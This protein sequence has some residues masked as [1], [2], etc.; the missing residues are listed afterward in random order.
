MRQLTWL[1]ILTLAT[2]TSTKADTV[3]VSGRVADAAGKPITGAEVAT[4]WTADDGAMK[5]IRGVKTDGD[6]KFRLECRLY[7]RDQAVMAIDG[8]R[9]HGGLAVVAAKDTER[10]LDIV[11]RP[12]VD[13]CGHFT[14]EET[15]LAPGWTNV[16]LSL[17]PGR[18][19][20]VQCSS[21][22]SKFALK[23]PPGKYEFYGYGSFTDFEGVTREVTLEQGKALEMGALDLEL[24][25]IARH[26]GKEPPKWHVAD[27]RGLP[28][29]KDVTWKDFRGKWVILE[30]WGFW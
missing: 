30:F 10:P 13:V 9:E 6:G 5:P 25:P 26:Y 4:F 20:V 1:S 15:K 12:L 16:Y 14:C 28:Q 11:V 7:G 2:I 23:M 29:G 17:L 27:A 21:K 18:V 24:T 22:E 19:R 3:V 8:E